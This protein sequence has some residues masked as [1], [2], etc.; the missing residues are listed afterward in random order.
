[1]FTVTLNYSQSEDQGEGRPICSG[2]RH[3]LYSRILRDLSWQGARV[4]IELR[5]RRFY[6]RSADCR[7]KIFTERFPNL[8]VAYGAP[9]DRGAGSHPVRPS[10]DRMWRSSKTRRSPFRMI[11][12]RSYLTPSCDSTLRAILVTV[13]VPS[14]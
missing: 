11:F 5:S 6:C 14:V 13:P 7:R 9:S 4:Q 2:H 10:M 3:S 8:T 1:R 12:S